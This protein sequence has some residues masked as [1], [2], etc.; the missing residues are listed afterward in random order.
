MSSISVPLKSQMIAPPRSMALPSGVSLKPRLSHEGRLSQNRQSGSGGID[1][2]FD[3]AFLAEV[4]QVS[5]PTALDRLQTL[6]SVR[7]A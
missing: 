2:Y 4:D 3:P 1:P 5:Q 7:S 6:K